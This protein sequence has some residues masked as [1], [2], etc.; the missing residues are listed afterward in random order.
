MEPGG[1]ACSS[2]GKAVGRQGRFNSVGGEEGGGR[3]LI[4]RWEGRRVELVGKFH[5][6]EVWG[7]KELS[8]D[9]EGSICR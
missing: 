7:Y 6:L 4:A 1:K 3:G 9:E 2:I 5:L 8:S